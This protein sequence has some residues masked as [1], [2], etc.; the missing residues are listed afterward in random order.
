MTM[1]NNYN[2]HMLNHIADFSQKIYDN[3]FWV[4]VNIL[5]HTTYTNQEILAI[6]KLE[7][8]LKKSKIHN[9]YEAVQCFQIGNFQSSDDNILISKNSIDLI[10][11][12]SGYKAHLTNRGCCS[13]IANWLNFLI[14]GIYS[15]TGEIIIISE[16]GGGHAINYIKHENNYYIID[17][18]PY[19]LS[20]KNYVTFESGNII[21]YRHSKFLTGI[22]IKTSSL[23]YFT[24]FFSKF[25]GKYKNIKFL[26]FQQTTECIFEGIKRSPNK[27]SL[28]FFN[29]EKI[30][31]IGKPPFNYEINNY[32][33]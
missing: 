5:G 9:L 25:M 30:K 19:L 32:F 27:L 24:E 26:F 1:N 17:L 21:D 14:S 2:S 20:N 29:T 22:L 18:T 11:H 10:F 3:I 4:P 28:Y 23:E 16:N 12:K 31:L 13:S 8:K 33:F 6:S 7:P 15:E